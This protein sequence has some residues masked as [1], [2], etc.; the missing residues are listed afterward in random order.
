VLFACEAH[1]LV[2][3]YRA[4][5][6]TVGPHTRIA[7][8]ERLSGWVAA[9]RRTIVNSDARLDFDADVRDTSALCTALAVPVHRNGETL[10]VLAFYADREDAFGAAHQ[11]L[12]EAAAYVT[13][14]ALHQPAVPRAA[15][16][17]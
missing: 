8:G 7:I 9:T 11:R 14:H 3:V 15:V 2:P 4:G 12:A 16:A 10:A 17:V 6:P 5:E 13:A 1:T